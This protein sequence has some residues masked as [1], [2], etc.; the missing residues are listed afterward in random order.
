MALAG[1]SKEAKKTVSRRVHLLA[2]KPSELPA[3]HFV[4]VQEELAPGPVAERRRILA[5]PDDV[6]E[7]HRGQHPVGLDL[8]M[9]ARHHVGEEPPQLGEER[10]L[11]AD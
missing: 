1:P 11:L 5:R 7:E 3:H 4:V 6:R 8:G 2:A 10:L 9:R